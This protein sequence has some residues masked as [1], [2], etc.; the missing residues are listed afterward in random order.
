[1]S[2]NLFYFASFLS[3]VLLVFYFLRVKIINYRTSSFIPFI[4]L[5]FI[6]T[7]Y[8]LFL[9]KWLQLGSIVWFRI[10]S[11]LEFFALYYYFY[12]LI[13]GYRIFFKI[14]FI[15]YLFLFLSLL[16]T[17]NVTPLQSDSYLV[18]VETV[19]VFASSILWFKQLFKNS[20]HISLFSFSNFYF[21][22]GLI[23]Y[24]S[25]I[26]TLELLSNIIFKKITSEFLNYWNLMIVFNIVLRLFIIVGLSKK[27]ID[28]QYII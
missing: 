3:A 15:F 22:S 12:N 26:L 24:Y 5:I 23:L 8:E 27:G 7:C 17:E 9:Y 20:I 4:W 1:M 6:A 2:E 21:V 19:F 28:K 14:I 10:Y 13:K 16:S 25:G 11:F 18:C